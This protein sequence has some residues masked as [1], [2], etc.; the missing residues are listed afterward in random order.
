MTKQPINSDK[1]APPAGPF[2]Q[3][4]R[5]DGFIFLSGQIGQDPATGELVEGGIRPQAEQVF[6]NLSAV[7]DAAG[8]SFADVVR[9]NVYLTS[10]DDFA[11]MNGIY[12]RH[13]PP[14]FPARTTVAVAALPMGAAI[15]IDLIVK[16]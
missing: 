12:T 16:S 11:A 13:M 2:S 5:S 10:M 8:K 6:M 7:L 15:E 4:I 9:A 3:A 14:P 1:L